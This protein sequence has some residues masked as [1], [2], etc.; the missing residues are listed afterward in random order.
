MN[1]RLRPAPQVA[2]SLLGLIGPVT[3]KRILDLGCGEGRIARLVA[4]RGND[5]AGV[6]LSD[7]L[8]RYS[9]PPNSRLT[10]VR[11]SRTRARASV[12]MRRSAAESE[13]WLSAA[14]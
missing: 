9:P 12:R 14:L 7:R 1:D 3:G 6:D 11:V 8:C 10:T 5:V 13:N 2:A 4:A